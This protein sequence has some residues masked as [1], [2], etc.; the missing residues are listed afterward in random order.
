MSPRYSALVMFR[1]FF[2]DKGPRKFKNF[3]ELNQGT[4]ERAA[5]PKVAKVQSVQT[6]PE[7]AASPAS[8]TPS[9]NSNRAAGDAYLVP[10]FSQHNEY[11]F[12]DLNTDMS[13]SRIGQPRADRK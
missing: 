12:Y 9:T 10:E 4:S 7:R 6:P 8:A 11:S 2:C 5:V 3:S 1:R 13:A